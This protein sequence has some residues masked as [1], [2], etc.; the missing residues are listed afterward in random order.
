VK[1][2]HPSFISTCKGLIYYSKKDIILWVENIISNQGYPRSVGMIA[3]GEPCMGPRMA[4]TPFAICLVSY[5]L[6]SNQFD[7]TLANT[8]KQSTQ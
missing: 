3:R 8:I 2:S 4:I 7:E 1:F 5:T 6:E